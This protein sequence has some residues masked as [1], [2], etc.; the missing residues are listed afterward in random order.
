MAS[1]QKKLIPIGREID[2]VEEEGKKV[3]STSGWIFE[4]CSLNALASRAK[5]AW[6]INSRIV[7]D[8]W[9]PLIEVIMYFKRVV[10]SGDSS[11]FILF[12]PSNSLLILTSSPWVKN[13]NV[14][15]LFEAGRVKVNSFCPLVYKD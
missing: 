8:S 7:L 14:I 5:K 11:F 13:L 4:I 6:S 10:N 15:S 2:F 1:G 9:S 3:K 12:N